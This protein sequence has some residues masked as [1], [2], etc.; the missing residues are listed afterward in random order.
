MLY[1]TQME[2]D[3]ELVTRLRIRD[4]YDWHQRAWECFPGRDR[5]NRDFL[6]RIEDKGDRIRLLIL[7]Q[8]SPTR[9]GWCPVEAW[10]GPKTIDDRFLSHRR[11]RFQ[12]CANPTKKVK[13][14]NADGS[15]RPNGRR[16]PLRSREDLMAWIRR[17]GQA[18]GFMPDEASLRTIPCGRGMFDRK[19]QRGLHSAV[20]FQGVLTVADS[21]RFRETFS[22]GLGSAKGFGFGLLAIVPLQEAK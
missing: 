11:Y 18:G 21:K 15:E 17:K 20:E 12:V 10:H 22:M 3:C 6:T 19:G 2:F 8:T 14:F 13:A 4:S 5:E 1:L 9:P 16:E 7:S